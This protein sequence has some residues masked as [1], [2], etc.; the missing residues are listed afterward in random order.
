M[1]TKQ[2]HQPMKLEGSKMRAADENVSIYGTESEL[3]KVS[4]LAGKFI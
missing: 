2:K 4:K 1:S 3:L